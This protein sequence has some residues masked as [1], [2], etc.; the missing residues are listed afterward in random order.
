M[1]EYWIIDPTQGKITVL[2]LV[3]GLYEEAVFQGSANLTSTT[4]P[5][6]KLKAAEVLGA[7]M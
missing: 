3:D 7:G 1:P 5:N 2:T 4:F 6:L